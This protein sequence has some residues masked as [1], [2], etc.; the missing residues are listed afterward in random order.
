MKMNKNLILVISII[1]MFLVASC[2]PQAADDGKAEVGEVVFGFVEPLTGDVSSYGEGN[3]QAVELAV[4]EINAAGGI[5]GKTLRVI[6][7]DGKCNAKDAVNAGNKLINVDGVKYI[8]GGLCSGE[9]LAI[10][11][12]AEDKGVIMMSPGSSSPDITNAGDY[13]F[14]DYVND[15]FVGAILA[16]EMYNAGHEKVALLYSLNDYSQGLAAVFVSEF[17]ALGGEIVYE[18]SFVQGTKDLRSL[19][20]KAKEAKAD[21]ITFL[22]YTQSSI[23]F[24][25]QKKELGLDVPVYGADVFADT[26]IVEGAGAAFDGTRY[27]ILADSASEEFKAKMKAKTGED[28][29]KLAS[30]NAYD[31]VYVL[32][33][34]V[35]A[36]GDNP[37]E[38]KDWLYVMEEY[39]GESGPISFDENGDLEEASFELWE[40]QAGKPVLVG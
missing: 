19:V 3:K 16:E 12:L 9:T 4:N 1:V 20:S 31:A 6:Y 5:A 28:D 21:G 36:V 10:A 22:G 27:L 2:A 39:S 33:S 24:F 8:I 34:A 13:I 18:E 35:N 26:E 38:V 15:N 37:A 40:I 7:E 14:R 30:A 11:P 32:A 29:L 25:K 23:A 17:E